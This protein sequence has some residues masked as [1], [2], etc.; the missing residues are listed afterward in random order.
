MAAAI[1]ILVFWTTFF[2]T[3]GT[4]RWWFRNT[5]DVVTERLNHLFQP[6]AEQSQELLVSPQEDLHTKQLKRTLLLAGMRRRS[7]LEKVV[8]LKK[9]CRAGAIMFVIFLLLAGFPLKQVL[10]VGFP[11]FAIALILPRFLLIRLIIKRR[12][13]IERNLP[14]V[15]DLLVLCLE[16]GL[17]LDSAFVR[18][19]EEERRVSTQTSRELLLT[20]QEILAG[21]P[22]DEA[23]R[24]LA[25]RCG[26][27]DLNSL[28]GAILQSMKLGT[29]LVKTL[30]I[31]A[32]VIRKKRKERIRA[33]ILKTPV[34]LIFPLLLFIFPTLLIVILGPS[35][36]NIFRHFD[37]VGV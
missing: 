12:K 31:Q 10:L 2:F 24:N 35:L 32:D 5:T 20:N 16:A 7:D 8:Y 36:I 1:S 17:S 37:A 27:P 22:R 6:Q 25:W 23:L 26:I 3:L 11:V 30:R 15:L 29:S 9:A 4:K 14:D 28:V 21:K 13:E 33:Q 19:A 18:V 34:K